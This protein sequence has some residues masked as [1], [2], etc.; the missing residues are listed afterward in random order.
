MGSSCLLL[1][2]AFNTVLVQAVVICKA[3]PLKLQGSLH[4]ED[5][6]RRVTNA[7]VEGRRAAICFDPDML[8]N[9]QVQEAAGRLAEHLIG[10]GVEIWIAYLHDQPDGSKTGRG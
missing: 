9:P 8:H 5:P 2:R 10:R 6:L 4:A 7:V 3:S 1:G